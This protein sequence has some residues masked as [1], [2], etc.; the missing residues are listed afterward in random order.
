MPM[1]QLERTRKVQGG[2]TRTTSDHA[3]L[4]ATGVKT[5]AVGCYRARVHADNPNTTTVAAMPQE[6]WADPPCRFPLFRSIAE[7]PVAGA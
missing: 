7:I 6:L 3:R 1:G 4:A 2:R 5:G